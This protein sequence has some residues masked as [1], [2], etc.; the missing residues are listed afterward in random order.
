MMS[1]P[2]AVELSAHMAARNAE[3]LMLDI[4]TRLVCGR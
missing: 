2:D 1:W 3:S 4:F